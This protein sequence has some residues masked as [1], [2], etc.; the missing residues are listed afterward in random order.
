MIIKDYLSNYLN[1][2]KNIANTSIDV[3]TV[4]V[5]GKGTLTVEYNTD[6]DEAEIL[7]YTQ[8]RRDNFYFA[9]NIDELKDIIAFCVGPLISDSEWNQ[10]RVQ[11]DETEDM[12]DDG[13]DEELG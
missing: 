1:F 9:E 6:K 3:Y 8:D 4:S 10:V 12:F 11:V 13:F 5:P 7:H 2:E